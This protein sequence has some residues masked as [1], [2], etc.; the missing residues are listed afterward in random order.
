VRAG[1][2]AG[3]GPG[4]A[5][6]EA[7]ATLPGPVQRACSFEL[8]GREAELGELHALW[9]GVRG[10]NGAAVVVSGDPGIGKTRLASELLAGA[11]ADGALVGAGAALELG[12]APPFGLWAELLR[13][14]APHLDAP[15][16]DAA[17]PSDL[18]RLA[19]DLE[20]RFGRTPS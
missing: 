12:G 14:L 8:V 19:P 2:G 1:A 11:V 15:P 18:G 9:A 10:G 6:D 13:D 4:R 5:G 3:A 20:R 7:R 16:P 17:W